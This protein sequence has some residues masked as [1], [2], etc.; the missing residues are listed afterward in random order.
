MVA[1]ELN[2]VNLGKFPGLY[3]NA[4]FKKKYIYT[5]LFL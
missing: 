3:R 2:G 4:T 1:A 5:C